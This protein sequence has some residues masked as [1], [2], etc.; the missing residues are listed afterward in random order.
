[1]AY[2]VKF[3]SGS[4]KG[5]H[6]RIPDGG[7]LTIGRSHSCGIRPKEADV[8]GKHAILS[9]KSGVVWLEVLSSH[10]TAV[11]GIRLP[12]GEKVAITEVSQV[13]LGGT[14]VFR[15]A[16]IADDGETGEIMSGESGM[17]GG[18]GTIGT[19]TVATAATRA[20]DTATLGADTG[21]L[22]GT[23]A[24]AATRAMGADTAMLGDETGT[25]GGTVATAATRAA[26]TREESETSILTGSVIPGVNGDASG[27]TSER[28]S[29]GGETQM[30]H[31]QI[32]SP[33]ELSKIK[34][35]YEK[36]SKR[37]VAKHFF[38]LGSVAFAAA[39]SSIWF[40]TRRPENPLSMPQNRKPAA[41][42]PDLA[43]ASA[44]GAIAGM[45][46]LSYPASGARVNKGENSIEIRTL[47][48]S[49]LDVEV[50]VAADVFEDDAAVGESRNATFMR[51]IS[52]SPELVKIL[53][54]MYPLPDE[55]FFGGLGG[56]FRGIPCSRVEYW[57]MRG[58]E[59]VYGV[60]SFFRSGTLCC[61]LRREV[62]AA[63]KERAAWLL[64]DTRTW[65]F[66]DNGGQFQSLQWEGA[67][68]AG[69]ADP[70]LEISRCEARFA[71]D[72]TAT[73]PEIERGIRDVLAETM[74][75][76]AYSDVRTQAMKL[77]ADLRT[78]KATNWKRLV[79]GRV[80]ITLPD[81]GTTDKMRAS[82]LDEAVRK[83]Y[84][85][86]DEEWYFLARRRRW[87]E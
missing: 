26:E 45:V 61:A 12:V 65:L 17:L 14:L 63:E 48:G 49:K 4:L 24:T 29:D 52:K 20:A 78:R 70:A 69:C 72:S 37:R 81:G 68:D 40:S 35:V 60:V 50:V 56:R 2:E 80:P 87:W 86:P 6:W 21:T 28:N 42:I 67:P 36:K 33:E 43:P 19:G 10:K 51:Y 13:T 62:P 73:W 79:A 38:L 11:D 82:E 34:D 85:S 59:N 25:L 46:G 74:G 27:E 83:D 77:L 32:A 18:T 75:D 55:D 71:V 54:N 15:L 47:I 76:D 1:M 7:V 64:V 3:E 22:S 84:P 23:V 30:L 16:K 44:K 8:S 58:R 39:V 66:A 41:I 57:R 9:E 53:D 5:K 31:T